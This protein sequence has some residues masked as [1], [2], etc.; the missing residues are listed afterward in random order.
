[1]T[2]EVSKFSDISV[3]LTAIVQVVI[4]RTVKVMD[5]KNRFAVSEININIDL[6]IT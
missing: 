2:D 5:H 6:F 3:I 4:S 1:M